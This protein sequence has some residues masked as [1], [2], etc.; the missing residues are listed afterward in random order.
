MA[1]ARPR[2][3]TARRASR[4]LI[5]VFGSDNSGPLL[6]SFGGFICLMTSPKMLLSVRISLLLDQINR[7]SLSCLSTVDVVGN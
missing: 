1:I 5:V 7:F 3:R 2:E 6:S 4:R